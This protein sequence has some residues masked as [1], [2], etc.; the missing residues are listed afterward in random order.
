MART[1]TQP[2]DPP[3][4]GTATS[5]ADRG[6]DAR[7]KESYRETVE[8]IAIA[9]I[10]ALLVRGF[11][12]EAFVIPTGSMAPTLM[13]RHKEIVCPQCGYKF[14]V[15]ASEEVEGVS[16][17]EQARER[18]VAAGICQNCRYQVLVSQEPSFKGDRILVMKFPYDLPFLPGASGPKRWDVVVFRYPEEPEVSY[19]K[20]LVG[21][22]GE[23]I[24]IWYGDVFVKPPGGK[25]FVLE[26]KPLAHQQAMQMLV[27][28]DSHRAVSLK[29]RPEWRRWVPAA[30]NEGTWSEDPL[31]PGT[32]R[33]EGQ[34]SGWNELR[35]RHV[36]PDPQQWRAIEA[37]EPL[38]RAPRPTLIT[39]FYSYNTNLPLH[40]AD[41]SGDVG[42]DQENAWLQPH[43]VGDLT[44]SARVVT[45]S[46]AGKVRFELI[47]GGVPN[48][49]E[50][51]VSTGEAVI[52]HGESV[53]GHGPSPL[54]GAGDHEVTFANVDN[55]LTLWVDGRPAF[56]D[57][58]A[59]EDAPGAH[60]E[61][62]VE[63]LS[64]VRI[65]TQG[66]KVS[67]S[68]LV[69]KRD[70]YYTQNPG[71]VDYGNAW[72]TRLPRNPVEL[73]DML[74]D[75]KR[76]AALG[77]LGWSDYQLGGDRYLMLGDNSPR[78]KDS[79]GWHNE[80]LEWDTVARQKHEVPRSMLTGKAFCVYWPHGKPFGPDIRVNQDFRL[81]FRPYF[82]RMGL[83]R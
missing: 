80:D 37:G 58:F 34:G 39:D 18:R 5:K 66:A 75:P 30:S 10:L 41:L 17:S 81:P 50:I 60:P 74:A 78:S 19:I 67:V 71:Y 40:R 23:T 72:D 22:A 82:E 44:V 47:E 57:G 35:Y 46:T 15:N 28:D 45:G 36:I 4:P 1:L 70:I 65:A 16:S 2:S 33:A 43:W 51:D 9:F 3:A 49:C 12:A 14:T 48:V 11:E 59:Y 27:Y 31:A 20:R 38:P 68:G 24:R 32:F 13:G 56:G 79:R 53:L 62:T 29:E 6:A 25:E 63:D 73:F 61:P 26:R 54:K 7:P 21:L 76:V 42:R 83:I 64:P 8:A 77:P 52:R 55:R 69:L